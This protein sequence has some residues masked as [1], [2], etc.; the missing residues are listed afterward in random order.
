MFV[1]F[2]FKKFISNGFSEINSIIFN[3]TIGK[4]AL[5]IFY[6]Y[7]TLVFDNDILYNNWNEFVIIRRTS[8]LKWSLNC[9]KLIVIR[10]IEYVCL[11]TVCIYLSCIVFN[12]LLV[13]DKE[14][15]MCLAL[16]LV[17]LIMENSFVL[18]LMSFFKKPSFSVFGGIVFNTA[19][20]VITHT[21]GTDTM[22]YSKLFYCL[23]FLVFCTFF[24]T[25]V[26][27]NRC[28]V[29]INKNHTHVFEK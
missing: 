15:I 13:V 8:R 23:L 19:V 1:L 3:T 14:T 6:G 11:T 16:L 12:V 27:M 10:Q 24:I 5:C 7:I 2:Q 17:Y 9:F 22:Y 4:Y 29:F 18:L 26:N 25:V 28:D 20:L 21:F